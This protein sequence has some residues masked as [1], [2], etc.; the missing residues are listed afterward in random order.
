MTT[1]SDLLHGLM[2]RLGYADDDEAARER[3][4]DLERR[5]AALDADIGAQEATRTRERLLRDTQ[6][7]HERHLRP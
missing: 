5:L 7:R 3:V 4:R 2:T 1:L 6:E